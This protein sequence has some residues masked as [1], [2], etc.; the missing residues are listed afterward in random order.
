MERIIGHP[1]DTQHL[2]L[3]YKKTK[4]LLIVEIAYFKEQLYTDH[5]NESILRII[6]SRS[7][8]D[9]HCDM[10]SHLV[11]VLHTMSKY[12]YKIVMVNLIEKTCGKKHFIYT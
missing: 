8:C 10:R 6:I 7:L 11:E 12:R 4:H 5:F 1:K 3:L 2:M 9:V